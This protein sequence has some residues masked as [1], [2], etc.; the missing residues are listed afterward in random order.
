MSEKLSTYREKIKEC[1]IPNTKRLKTETAFQLWQT[2]INEGEESEVAFWLALIGENHGMAAA[3]CAVL[4]KEGEFD[5]Y[6]VTICSL[7]QIIAL[8]TLEMTPKKSSL[9]RVSAA[10]R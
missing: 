3:F 10:A 9:S 8:G 4:V 6:P 1:Y 2:A 7:E 5:N